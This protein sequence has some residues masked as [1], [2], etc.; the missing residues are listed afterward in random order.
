M[1]ETKVDELA[2]CISN[3]AKNWKAKD[4]TIGRVGIVLSQK[5]TVVCDQ[6]FAPI[7]HRIHFDFDLGELTEFDYELIVLLHATNVTMLAKLLE[8]KCFQKHICKRQTTGFGVESVQLLGE[9]GFIFFA[10]LP[11]IIHECLSKNGTGIYGATGELGKKILDFTE[12]W[13]KKNSKAVSWAKNPLVVFMDQDLFVFKP[14]FAK[15]IGITEIE[16]QLILSLY[17]SG[18][19]ELLAELFKKSYFQ[20]FQ[21]YEVPDFKKLSLERNFLTTVLHITV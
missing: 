15:D 6:G 4:V 19:M 8:K 7:L 16:Y 11:D 14:R 17:S 1:S 3:F 12:D 2:E 18:E 5:M 20:R 13:H 10:K 21:A 9:K